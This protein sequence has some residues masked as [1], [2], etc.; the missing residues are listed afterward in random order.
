[1]EKVSEGVI[2]SAT[3]EL[4][5]GCEYVVGFLFSE[6]GDQVIL[7]RK[8]RP[9]WQAGFY[10]GV[11]GKI[12][13]GELPAAAM[14]R[15]GIEEIGVNPEWS[16]YARVSYGEHVL[17]FFAARDQLAFLDARALTDEIVVRVHASLAE[18]QHMVIPNLR[19]LI[20]LAH[21]HLFYETVIAANLTMSGSGGA[22]ARK[23]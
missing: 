6:S 14:M 1:V 17:H 15:E 21:H 20:P 8:N 4:G 5:A 3:R 19:W 9:V 2:A 7:V 23:M 22:V 16:P 12:E 10:N 13:P 18:R 11:G